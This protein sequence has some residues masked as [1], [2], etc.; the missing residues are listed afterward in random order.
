MASDSSNT[1]VRRQS[2]KRS[3]DD[4]LSIDT[5]LKSDSEFEPGHYRRSSED[6]VRR[7][8]RRR[9]GENDSTTTK[10]GV[11]VP[12]KRA[13]AR[14]TT[15]SPPRTP[16]LGHRPGGLSEGL[17]R[18]PSAVFRFDP[19]RVSLRSRSEDGSLIAS[20]PLPSSSQIPPPTSPPKSPA[21][22]QR[23]KSSRWRS[24][25][26]GVRKRLK[27]QK[28]VDESCRQS[29][30]VLLAQKTMALELNDGVDSGGA[31]AGVSNDFQQESSSQES[32][33][34]SSSQE[35]LRKKRPSLL[36]KIGSFFNRFSGNTDAVDYNNG[37]N[38][39]DEDDRSPP[40]SSTIIRKSVGRRSSY[41]EA[42]DSMYFPLP[43]DD[44]YAQEILADSARPAAVASGGGR[45]GSGSA[46][47]DASVD[48]A[49]EAALDPVIQ[50]SVVD[51][52]EGNCLSHCFIFHSIIARRN[53]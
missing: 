6:I 45:G 32:S 34:E 5:L 52:L 11:D 36:D 7:F 13:R 21:T 23:K 1:Y 17:E 9:Y 42:M 15:D 22:L 30:D 41:H 4:R 27:R 31:S 18:I 19:E 48:T 10:E 53:G 35:S 20:P 38:D 12:A 24:L 14:L 26:K 8:L 46:T 51:K 16:R 49:A 39:E 43:N 29:S 2:S 44:E 3:R 50:E 25:K 47:S 37:N 28:T 40:A 33:Q